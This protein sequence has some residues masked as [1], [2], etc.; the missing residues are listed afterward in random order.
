ME[1]Y[2][3]FKMFWIGILVITGLIVL[4]YFVGHAAGVDRMKEGNRHG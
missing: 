3:T 1:V 4:A 2:I